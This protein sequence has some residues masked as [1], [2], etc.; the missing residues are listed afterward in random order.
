VNTGSVDEATLQRLVDRL[1]IQD[2]LTMY[3]T[4]SDAKDFANLRACFTDD[5]RARYGVESDWLE[6]GDEIVAWLEGAFAPLDWGHH[7]VSVYG[8]DLDGDQATALMYL[9]SHQTVSG[10]PDE[11]LSM[12][13]KY[14]NTLRRSSGGWQ[15]SQLDLEI[16]WFEQRNNVKQKE[17]TT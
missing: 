11:V 12:T 5:A 8:V 3:A 17:L 16:G 13:A 4:A 2:T 1:D 7:L 6:G 10:T 15:I 14:R 9:L